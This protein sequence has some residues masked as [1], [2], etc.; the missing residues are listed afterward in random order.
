MR[1]GLDAVRTKSTRTAAAARTTAETTAAHLTW[2]HHAWAHALTAAALVHRHA[3]AAAP[4]A[5]FEDLLLVCRQCVVERFLGR[6]HFLQRGEAILQPLFHLRIAF[7]QRGTLA[8][9]TVGRGSL[10]LT[11]RIAI[12]LRAIALH[13]RFPAVEQRLLRRGELQPRFDIGE[14]RG[15]AGIAVGAHLVASR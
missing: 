10:G 6:T 3:R 2:A 14:L 9:L 5:L 7:D 8:G 1:V 12:G 13:G 11:R 4:I 15:V